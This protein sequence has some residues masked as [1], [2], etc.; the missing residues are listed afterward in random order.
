MGARYSPNTVRRRAPHSPVVT[1]A[2]AASI[3]GGMM[4]APERAACSRAS[5]AWP[6][7]PSSRR[8]RHSRMRPCASIST[9][10]ETEKIA[11][12]RR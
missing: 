12:S 4:L 9:V 11:P 3:E 7:A 1:P 2:F 5:R 8:L 10:S 6:T